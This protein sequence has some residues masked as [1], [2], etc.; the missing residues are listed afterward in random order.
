LVQTLPD[1]CKVGWDDPLTCGIHELCDHCAA[2]E[3]AEDRRQAAEAV[4]RS[5]RPLAERMARSLA[6]HPELLRDDILRASADD[7]VKIIRAALGR[8]ERTDSD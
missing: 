4:R 1:A 2:A 8:E 5:T 7:L 6:A 3:A